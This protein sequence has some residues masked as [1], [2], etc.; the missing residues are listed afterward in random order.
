MEY[1]IILRD[2]RKSRIIFRGQD[3]DR[4]KSMVDAMRNRKKISTISM[5]HYLRLVYRSALFLVLL[6]SYVR[7]RLFSAEPIPERIEQ[8]PSSS[9]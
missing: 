3:E 8:L 9:I 2:R 4:N 7:F 5:L 6:I 1:G